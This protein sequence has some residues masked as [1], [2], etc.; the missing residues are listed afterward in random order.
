MSIWR[1]LLKIMGWDVDKNVPQGIS[2]MVIVVGPHT[3]NWDFIIGYLALRSYKV[4]AKFLIK[5]EL[6]KGPLGW[7]LKNAGGV[8]VDR[9]NKNKNFTDQ[10]VRYFKDN[11]EMFLIFTPEA[12]R[13]YNP[14]WK[15]GFYYIAKRAKVPIYLCYL[16]YKN[17]KGGFYKPFE[18]TGNVEEDIRFIKNTLSQFEGKYPEKGIRPVHQE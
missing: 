2:K 7:F 8:P 17:K 12:T 9:K 13:S 3:S 15:L 16:D 5:K 14:D 6:F 4:K 10:A 1:V 18:M 11:D